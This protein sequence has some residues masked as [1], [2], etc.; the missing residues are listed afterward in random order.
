MSRGEF[1]ALAAGTPTGAGGFQAVAGAFA[2]QGVFELGD[3]A[4]PVQFRHD[5][6]VAGPARRE[7]FAQA[8]PGLVGPEGDVR[9]LA[10]PSAEAP[11]ALCF[12]RSASAVAGGPV[13]FTSGASAVGGGGGPALSRL[14]RADP[15][16]RELNPAPAPCVSANTSGN[17]ALYWSHREGSDAD[18]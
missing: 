6:L 14:A 10:R 5:E 12:S 4:E 17:R 13:L 2:H 3:G 11:M 8:G 15:P 16:L 18:Q 9:R 1:G 7:G